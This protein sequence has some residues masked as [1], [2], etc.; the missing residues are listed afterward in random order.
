MNVS[1]KTCEDLWCI[2]F[3]RSLW[4]IC[5]V[6]KLTNKLNLCCEQGGKCPFFETKW[7]HSMILKFH[8]A[9]QATH[10][11]VCKSLSLRSHPPSFRPGDR[12]K[13]SVSK[14]AM[15]CASGHLKD[16]LG[17]AENHRFVSFLMFWYVSLIN[18][19]LFFAIWGQNVNGVTSVGGTTF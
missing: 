5:V 1:S 19:C 16:A 15:K 11:K 2:L 9:Y 18:F 13:V 8:L 4:M 10:P 12:G 3:L 17:F 14:E 6:F 7:N